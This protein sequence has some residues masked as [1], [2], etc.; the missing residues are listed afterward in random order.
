MMTIS[1]TFDLYSP[2]ALM[3]HVEELGAALALWDT[4][5]DTKPQPEVRQAANTAVGEI[6]TLL[7]K[8]HHIRMHLVSE[9][10]RSDDAGAARVDAL[11]AADRA[12]GR[13]GA[14]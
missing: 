14:R 5:D 6:D 8:L 4:R 1:T 11:L 9:V 3:E 7:R 2:A 10:R 13:R 12:A